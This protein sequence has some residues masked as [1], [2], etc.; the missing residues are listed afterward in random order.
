MLYKTIMMELLEQRPQLHDQLRKQRKLL[1]TLETLAQQ[2]KTS[3]EAWKDQLARTGP[4][5]RD[6]QITSEAL[7]IALQEMV[8]SLPDESPS[9][10]S[11]PLSLDGAMAFLRKATPPA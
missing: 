6:S 8:N 1:A 5:S 2:L 7:E 3:H 9:G 4:E 10:G 11:G